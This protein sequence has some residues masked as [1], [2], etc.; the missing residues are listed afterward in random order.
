MRRKMLWIFFITLLVFSIPTVNMIGVTVAQETHDI[1]VTNVT[2][3]PDTV[4]IGE[5]VSINVTVTNEGDYSE[6]FNVT[7][8]YDNTTIGT[9]PVTNLTALS[10]VTLTFTWDTT[11]AR[12][13]I[14]ATDEKSKSYI[15]NAT[16]TIASDDDPDDNTSSSKV[17]VISHYIEVV[18]QSTVDT[19]L[20]EGM[21]YTVSICTD[22]NGSDV[23]G[24]EF[25]FTYNPLVLHG[26]EVT[27]GDLITDT[28]LFITLGFDN[29]LG[30]LKKT[31]NGFF[32]LPGEPI[33]VTSGPGTL[34][35]V[36][37]EVVGTGDSYITLGTETLA[38]TRL[39]GVNV[40]TEERYNI[41][42]DITPEWYH[43]L[44]GYFRNTA[45]AVTHDIAVISVT[46]NTT[47]AV[48]GELVD[49]TVVVENQGNVK[50]K[51]DVEAYFDYNPNF[52]TFNRIG[53]ETVSDLAAG[54]NKSLTFTWNT[55]GLKKKNRTITGV[56]SEL[57]GETDTEDNTL[58]SPQTVNVTEVQEQ[59]LPLDLII[60]VS[61]AV[62]VVLMVVYYAL[63]RRKKPTPE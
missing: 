37:F 44:H 22:Y 50:E 56:V 57:A 40:T 62:V 34:A 39:I 41:I 33:N 4:K 43:I 5:P 25:D 14:Y 28:T 63:K 2:A 23:W 20:T 17:K 16:A 21:N 46:P 48:A 9:Q 27:N 54:A 55:T 36:T 58:Q 18:P 19:N 29:E 30:K 12:E 13:E 59:P 26:I 32:F 51:F 6:T 24:W 47:S 11:D 53:N 7:A 15:V 3:S 52:P 10:E 1:A 8:Y 38:P 49:I 45:E 42:D 60:G 61:I 35:N 31:G